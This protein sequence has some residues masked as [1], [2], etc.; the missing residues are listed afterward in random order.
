MDSQAPQMDFSRI[1]SA[2]E[3]CRRSSG[4]AGEFWQELATALG[5]FPQS[6]SVRLLAKAVDSWKVMATHP[7]GRGATHTL[8]QE[9]FEALQAEADQ[10]NFVG[11][12]LEPL[13]RGYLL[14]VRLHTLE[15]A[16]PVYCEMLLPAEPNCSHEELTAIF[17]LAA[18]APR[19][20]E[21]SLKDRK[22]RDQL[23]DFS[24]ALEVLTA[25]NARRE[26]I[27]AAM[28]LVNEVAIRYQST[29]VSLG[30]IDTY[31]AKV[32]AMSGT[33]RYESKVEVVQRLE[34][35]MEEC[36]DQEEEIL[37]PAEE[38]NVIRRAHEA[39]L[40]ESHVGAVISVPLRVDGEV[41]AVL[42]L[43]R[44]QGHFTVDEAISLRVI[45][46]QS[47]PVLADLKKSS[48]WFGKRWLD[49]WREL[50]SKVLGPRH[51]WM[52]VGAVTLTLFLAFALL[53]PY[54][55]RVK[56][57]FI[58]VPDSLAL[59]PVPFNGYIDEVY[60]R[61][62]DVVD[63]GDTLMTLDDGEVK[64]EMVRATAD[65][66]RFTAEAERAE[67]IGEM[68]E[69]RVA[70]EL[71][72]QAE[73]RL[74]LAQYRLNRV[75][76]RAPFNGVLVEGDLRERLGAPV[77]QGEVLMKFSRLDELFLKIDLPE[78]DIDLLDGSDQGR[79]AFASRPD[80]KFPMTIERIEPSAVAGEGVNYF[81][82]R[83]TLDNE[84]AE[85][86]RP[87]MTGVAKLNAGKRTLM[88]RATHRLVDF[89]RMTFWI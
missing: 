52:K 10:S 29:R 38:G 61:P 62:G 40:Q 50:F 39:Y 87:G 51:T 77:N 79:L 85:W 20:F 54:T 35:A 6:R 5:A 23:D 22:V 69:F 65:L 55:Y 36:R 72:G 75:A 88:W 9:D 81:V 73:A 27:P 56:A 26:F 59:M 89:L 44:E 41:C 3:T 60:F 78:R 71:A 80:L 15:A 84:Q 37:F 19:T 49:S 30:W 2:L 1:I 57:N 32:C 43:E 68:G 86:L 16:F 13:N 11:R 48:R 21:Q 67:A 4:T 45:A 18:D 83:A 53:F 74:Q 66:R 76:I 47:A 46:D 24:R 70:R 42:T 31:Y 82:I 7:I 58:V 8:S 63:A 17:S 34:A 12:Q 64:V 14:L 28:A 25:V 33:D